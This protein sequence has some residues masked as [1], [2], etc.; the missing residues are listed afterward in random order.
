MSNSETAGNPAARFEILAL[1]FATQRKC[2]YV[3]TWRHSSIKFLNKKFCTCRFDI[4]V[5]VIVASV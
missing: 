4:P 1:R 3:I 5:Q 2:K